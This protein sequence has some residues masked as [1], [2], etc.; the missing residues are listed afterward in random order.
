M[1][2]FTHSSPDI[3]LRRLHLHSHAQAAASAWNNLNS[4][5]STNEL[6]FISQE[7]ASSRITSCVKPSFPVYRIR[8]IQSLLYYNTPLFNTLH[9]VR[10]CNI[11]SFSRQRL[12]TFTSLLHQNITQI[13]HTMGKTKICWKNN[14][15]IAFVSGILHNFPAHFCYLFTH[16]TNIYNIPMKYLEL[17][18]K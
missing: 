5:Q 10:C 15:G 4:N 14:F 18:A 3:Q 6:L 12:Y 17:C 11:V 7:Q 13:H 2:D 9:A 16:S 1:P 8:S